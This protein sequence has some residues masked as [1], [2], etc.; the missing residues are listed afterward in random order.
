MLTLVR[1]QQASGSAGEPL[2]TVFNTL[3]SNTVHIRQSQLTLIAAAPGVGKSL[4]SLT[5]ALQA[6]VPTLYMSA[7]SDEFVMFTRAAAML[8]GWT[9]QEVE[10][11]MNDDS[12]VEGRRTIIAAMNAAQHIR[13]NFD[14]DPTYADLERELE[15]F[16]GVYG[17]FPKLVVVDN[18]ANLYNPDGEGGGVKETCQYLKVV[19][20]MTGAAVVALHHVTGGYDDGNIAVPLSGL[21]EKISK[22]PEVVLTLDRDPSRQLTDGRQFMNVRPVK[23]RGGKADPSGGWALS[24]NAYMDR[25]KLTG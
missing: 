8:T 17:E 3:A 2:P 14:P 21:I 9:T 18:L 1:A 10:S 6:G 20:R 22:I 24:L 7:D 23:N 11:A 13:W 5:L 19:A 25:M 4:V 15:A 12:T 16:A